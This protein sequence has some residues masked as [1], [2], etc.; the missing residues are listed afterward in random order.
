MYLINGIASQTLAV[1]DRGLAFGDGFFTTAKI[2]SGTILHWHDHL[3]RL[4]DCAQRLFITDISWEKLTRECQQIAANTDIGVLKVVITRG[5]GGRGYST[6]DCFEPTRI[7]SVHPYPDFY[8]QWRQQGIKLYACQ[9]TIGSNTKL[10]GLK[11][12]N[13]LDQVMIKRELEENNAVEGLVCDEA[14]VMVETC[15]AN[16]YWVKAGVIFTPMLDRAGINGV[17]QK[18]IHRMAEQKDIP[19]K[20][21]HAS[22]D[23]LITA[24][25]VFISNS[26]MGIVPVSQ[27]KMRHFDIGKLCRRLQK[28]ILDV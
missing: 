1:N 5:A 15:T 13:R 22:A 11:T 28:E 14:G 8:S 20:Q 26:L 24:E 18:Q 25:E 19:Y 16:L 10:A 3:A 17:M 21:I 23:S 6:Q 7:V 2:T 12:L 9:F 4:E 27:Y